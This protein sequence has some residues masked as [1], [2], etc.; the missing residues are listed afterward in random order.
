MLRPLNNHPAMNSRRSVIVVEN[1]Y[2][3]PENVREY[4]LRQEFYTPY[5]DEADLRAGRRSITWWASRF[6]SAEECPFK[7]SRALIEAMSEA[8]GEPIDTGHWR[9]PFAVDVHSK[10]LRAAQSGETCLWNCC[11]HV[12]PAIEQ[13]LGNGV[14]NHVVDGWNSVGPNGWVGL[15]YL[16]PIAPVSGGLHLWRNRDASRQF[17]WMTS[18]ADWELVDSFGNI[19]NRLILV[20]GDIP[21]SGADGW[22]K[23][24]DE[25]RLYQTFFFR[26][27]SR[28]SAA[29]AAPEDRRSQA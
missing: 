19:F 14:H 1:F 21:H 9:A 20:R 4:A 18:P 28:T 3:D 23:R 13:R 22:G 16:N 11:F 29:T 10:P 17:D 2:E 5:E 6:R 7:S 27:N 8:V 12:K 25:G 24:L 15:I 26:T